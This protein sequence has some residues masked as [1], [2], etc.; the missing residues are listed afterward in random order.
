MSIFKGFNLVKGIL[1]V[2]FICLLIFVGLY[3]KEKHSNSDLRK[4]LFTQSAATDFINQQAS[5]VATTSVSLAT[6]VIYPTGIQVSKGSTVTW[7]NS[8][9]SIYTITTMA[10]APE[11]FTSKPLAGGDSYS[12]EFTKAGVYGYYVQENPSTMAGVITVVD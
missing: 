5:S 11:E 9:D 2:V 12:F 10:D 6:G 4:K 7:L 1:T 3:I 8:D